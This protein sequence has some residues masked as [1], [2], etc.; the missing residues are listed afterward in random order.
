MAVTIRE[1]DA[2]AAKLLLV[3]WGISLLLQVLDPPTYH[4][5]V[6][7]AQV[8]FYGAV[9]FPLVLQLAI[10]AGIWAGYRWVKIAFIALN[11]IGIISYT[12]RSSVFLSLPFD[13]IALVILAQFLRFWAVVIVLKDLLTR[14]P[15]AIGQL[16][17]PVAPESA[18]AGAAQGQQEPV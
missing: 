12:F 8:T 17:H 7:A 5:T 6:L 3:S 16:E 1:N 18:D 14:Q 2:R 4:P 9:A 15:A 11:V 13:R 10:G